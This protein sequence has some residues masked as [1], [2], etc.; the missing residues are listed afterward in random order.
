MIP[1][2][3]RVNLGALPRPILGLFVEANRTLRAAWTL[4]A[5]LLELIRLHSAFEHACHT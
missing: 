3:F 2:G 5:R 1:G 4:D